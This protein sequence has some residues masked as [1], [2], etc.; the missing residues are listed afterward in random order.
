[1]IRVSGPTAGRMSASTESRPPALTAMMTMSKVRGLVTSSS[2]VTTS[3]KFVRS[4][5]GATK[6]SPP[7]RTASARACRS[8]NVTLRP[9]STR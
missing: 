6:R 5:S 3:T 4:A 1:M 8:R 2:A 9:A 7:V